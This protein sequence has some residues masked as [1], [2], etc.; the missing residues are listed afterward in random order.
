MGALMDGRVSLAETL[1][2]FSAALCSAADALGWRG[3]EM[4]AKPAAMA[5]LILSVAMREG[6]SDVKRLALGA[7]A[8]SLA[9]DTL[10]LWPS[11]FAPGLAA[12]VAAHGFFIAT[13]ARGVGFLPSRLAALLIGA[14][15]ALAL[16]Y[17]W[18]GVDASLKAPVALYVGIIAL[19]ASQAAGR[20]SV[21]RDGAALAVA[22]G[23]LMFMISDMTIA[24]T[25]F[26]GWPAGQWT[27][28]TYYLAQG[29]IAFFI[30]PRARPAAAAPSAGRI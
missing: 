17:V 15:A 26:A 11:L 8:A 24:L 23:G 20:A 6:P 4:A 21:L 1:F 22:A 28:P 10:L 9:G 30:L 3:V 13:F 16:A 12:F 18:P 2:V 19:M 27:L 29:L 5:L 7:F 14:F 25:K